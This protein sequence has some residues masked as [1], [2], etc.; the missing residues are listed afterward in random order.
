VTSA[1]RN[2]R[3]ARVGVEGWV[4]ALEI[5]GEGEGGPNSRSPVVNVG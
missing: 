1:K 3:F 2:F 5:M 4:L